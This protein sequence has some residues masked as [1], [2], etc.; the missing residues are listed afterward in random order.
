[1]YKV[2]LKPLFFLF[3]PET[4]HHIVFKLIKFFCKIPGVPAVL[5]GCY[6]VKDKRLERKLFGLTFPNPVGLA[7]GFDKDAKLFDELGY[8]GFGFIEIGTLTPEAQPGNDKPR[9]FRL[10]QDEALINRMGFNNG[11]AE[12]AALRLKHRK[13][14]VLIGGNI[15]KNKITPNEEAVSDYE[16]CFHALV[17]HVDYF[18]VNVSS[19]NTPNL[20]ALQDKEPLTRLLNTIKGIN[21]KEKQPKPILLKIAP[22]LSNEQ[23]DDI[24]SI[25][26]ETKIDGLIATNTT[27]NRSDLIT[28][29]TVVE[30]MGAGGLSGKPLTK[31][32]TE[33][34]KYLSDRS[35]KSFP[36]IAVGGIHTGADAIEKLKAGASLVQIY[37]GFIYEGPGI[38]KRINKELLKQGI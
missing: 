23:L 9:M 14:P 31:R 34:I 3:P 24:I 12:P 28:P 22:D 25:M 26:N 36:I 37:T 5:K 38:V 8:F 27:I 10:P 16:K 19:P 6:A 13:T 4:I 20:R 21:S 32:S 11:G 2:I 18:V 30:A 29:K 17:D 7:A 15:G 1:M 33:V 35:N